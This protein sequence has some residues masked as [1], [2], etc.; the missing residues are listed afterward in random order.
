MNTFLFL[1]QRYEYTVYFVYKV[2][3]LKVN[4]RE[5]MNKIDIIN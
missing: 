1:I 4:I 3:V 5:K 2:K